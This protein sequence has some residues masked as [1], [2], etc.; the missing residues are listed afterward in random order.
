MA[1]KATIELDAGLVSKR[2]ERL[3]EVDRLGFHDEVEEVTAL[4]AA[5]AVPELLLAAD[6]EA[7]RLLGVEWAETHVLLALPVQANVTRDHL[8]YVEA[9]L[10]VLFGVPTGHPQD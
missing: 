3:P 10:D 8:D 1:T 4:A 6:R 9:I 7:R 2:L 5:E